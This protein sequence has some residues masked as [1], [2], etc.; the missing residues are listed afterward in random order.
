MEREEEGQNER[1]GERERDGEWKRKEKG[2]SVWY[3]KRKRGNCNTMR[4]ARKYEPLHTK[5]FVP[6]QNDIQWDLTNPNT[7]GP[8][9]VHISESS[10]Y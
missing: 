8:R 5:L 10:V 2:K 6:V 1:E 4:H 3:E 9:G 7:L